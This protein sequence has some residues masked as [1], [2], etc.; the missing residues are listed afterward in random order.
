MWT[1]II[2]RTVFQPLLRQVAQGARPVVAVVGEGEEEDGVVVV[3]GS[4]HLLD[5]PITPQLIRCQEWRVTRNEPL[6][7]VQ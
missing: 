5:Q 4:P 7:L 6:R 2:F 3:I 1:W